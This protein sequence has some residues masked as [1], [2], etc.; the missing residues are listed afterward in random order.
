MDC[1]SLD[2]GLFFLGFAALFFPLVHK[3]VG[4]TIGDQRGIDG[5]LFVGF[6]DLAFEFDLAPGLGLLRSSPDPFSSVD[7]GRLDA[8]EK[9]GGSVS[10]PNGGETMTLTHECFPAANKD[11]GR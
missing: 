1:R 7:Q 4:F 11:F 6:E 2:G 8:P 9:A 3:G 10:G 5:P